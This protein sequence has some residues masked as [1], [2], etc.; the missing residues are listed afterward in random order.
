MAQVLRSIKVGQL[1]DLAILSADNFSVPAEE[2]PAIHS[3]YTVLGGKPVWRAPPFGRPDPLPV[4]PD[5]SPVGKF[6]H[7]R[8]PDLG[9]DC[10]PAWL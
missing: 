9:C 5:W 3:L 6:E 8:L 7:G 10:R 1:A 2:I 4:S